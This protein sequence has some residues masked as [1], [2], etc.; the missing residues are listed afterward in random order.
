MES[1]G[2]VALASKDSQALRCGAGD[3]QTAHYGYSQLPEGVVRT[4]SYERIIEG[5]LHLLGLSSY[6]P[7]PVG[8]LTIRYENSL[9]FQTL[10]LAWQAP[11]P[12]WWSRHSR[13]WFAQMKSKRLVSVLW[14]VNVFPQTQQFGK[15]TLERT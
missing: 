2:I 4:L 6:A 3:G 11:A 1:S 12:S 13:L 7:K 5:L 15:S 8:T 14:L 9:S 10:F